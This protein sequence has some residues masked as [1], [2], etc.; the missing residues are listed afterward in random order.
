LHI[1]VQHSVVNALVWVL[2][3]DLAQR[4]AIVPCPLDFPTVG[5]YQYAVADK[6]LKI[7]QFV[8]FDEKPAM[9]SLANL[10]KL[11]CLLILVFY[12]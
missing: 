4:N 6:G 1:L 7:C 10:D 9:V 8:S 5:Y 12:A 11:D 3:Y 2:D